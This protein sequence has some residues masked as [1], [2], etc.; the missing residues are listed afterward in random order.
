M[1]IQEQAMNTFCEH[2][3]IS[4]KFGYRC[5]DRI[6]LNLL[7][8]ARRIPGLK[9]DY[10]RQLALMH[11]LVRFGPHRRRKYKRPDA[12]SGASLL[13]YDMTA[14]SEKAFLA[15]SGKNTRYPYG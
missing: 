3:Q 4:I 5:F 14:V 13:C 1:T 15:R 6:F 10:P 9:L 11:A 8:Q 2:H 7:I 12:S